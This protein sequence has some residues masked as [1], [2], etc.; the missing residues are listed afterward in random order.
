M[1]LLRVFQGAD[2]ID[3]HRT[4]TPVR[5][6]FLFDSSGD[7]HILARRDENPTTQGSRFKYPEP[8]EKEIDSSSFRSLEETRL[9]GLFWVAQIP[10]DSKYN[11]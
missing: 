10:C 9:V 3:R 1:H 7:K 2:S 8:E 11:G 6:P 4:K 5:S